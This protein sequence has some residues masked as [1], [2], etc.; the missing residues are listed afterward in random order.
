MAQPGVPPMRLGDR[1]Q[2]SG[3]A[4]DG[5]DTGRVQTS[6][7]DDADSLS[8]L[9]GDGPINCGGQ[10]RDQLPRAVAGPGW[11]SAEAVSNWTG[12]PTGRNLG[13]E[14]RSASGDREVVA[15]PVN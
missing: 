1:Q 14:S 13:L 6:N 7:G 9:P 12:P 2:A 3:V 5:N 15:G 8:I 4:P 10:L 11:K